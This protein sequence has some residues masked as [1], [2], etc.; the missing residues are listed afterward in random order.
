MTGKKI[1]LIFVLIIAAFVISIGGC[2]KDKNIDEPIIDNNDSTA[3]SSEINE[4]I[5]DNMN[6][7]YLWYKDVPNLRDNRF[8]NVTELKAFL[9]T[10][11]NRHEDL[12]DDLLYQ[13]GTV[14]R[15]SWIVDDY[16]ALLNSFQGVT[17]SMGMEYGLYKYSNSDGV[18]GVIEYVIPNTPAAAADI[19]RGEI[20]IAIN[21]INLDVNN[22][23]SLLFEQDA[24]E[25]SFASINNNTI[26]P[27]GK[28]VS[29][30][31]VEIH[32]NPIHYTSV[33]ESQG[34]KIGYLVYNSFSSEDTTLQIDYNV[35][36]NNVFGEFK[37]A[38]IQDLI[39]DLRYNGGGFIQTAVYLAS[40][41]YEANPTKVFSL[42]QYNDKLE[43]Y[44]R[45]EYG[46][47]IFKTRFEAGITHE[48]GADIPINSLN[49][50]RVYVI[51]TGG[52]A[53]ASELVINGL[54][55]Y[56]NVTL[57]GD[58][59]YGKNVGSRTIQD[60]DNGVVNPHHT[61]ALQ[62]II[63]KSANS[64]GNSDYGNGFVP[65]IL[66]FEKIS[67]MKPFGDENEPLLRAALNAI[68]G[69]PQ[70][71]SVTISPFSKVA[72]SK[73]LKPHS[74][75]MYFEGDILPLNFRNKK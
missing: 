52:S 14:D 15:F 3:I 8:A 26:S 66:I 74:K 31:A 7:W 40:M 9:N 56:M 65:D 44:Y 5:W 59:T 73:D 75:E 20:F 36:L 18:Y 67:E 51:T 54:K 13:K 63:L 32:E 72:D 33:I 1:R 47:D 48:S 34:K 71:K 2:K 16:V 61:W 29:L 50:N 25:I 45:S 21:G 10:Y 4:F 41:I 37:S 12:F 35:E 24:F 53:S 23:R 69:V 30:T 49:L 11:S 22:Y 70:T 39:L 62:P 58:T 42:T 68:N 60:T 57:V 17:K 19:K 46:A 64:I 38:G 27:N 6:L 28:S 43:D 55:P